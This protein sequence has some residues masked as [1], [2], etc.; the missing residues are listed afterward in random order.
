M[1]TSAKA[2]RQQAIANGEKHYFTGK[3]CKHGHVAP[4]HVL[5][6]RCVTCKAVH[7]ETVVKQWHDTNKAKVLTTKKQY[8][9][10]HRD[11]Y[12]E[13]KKDF[14]EKNKDVWREYARQWR[15]ANPEKVLVSRA[16]RR[17]D[18]IRR[19]PF[20]LTE[21]DYAEIRNMY[22]LAIAKTNETGIRWHVDHIIP[23]KGKY[24]SGLHVPQNLRVITA[25]ENLRKGNRYIIS[26][27]G[28]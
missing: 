16:K 1:L 26:K 21:G 22:R 20:W 5:Q 13:Q 8:K 17:A 9:V 14:Y 15:E 23:L 25:T 27:H 7:S 10:R 12:L 3:P 4:R 19:T 11:K 28:D 18:E 24:V 2:L 6:N